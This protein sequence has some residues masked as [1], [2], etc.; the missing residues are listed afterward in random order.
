MFYYGDLISAIEKLGKK[1]AI[2]GSIGKSVLG[3]D[4]PYVLTE[5][6]RGSEKEKTVIITGGIHAR[7]HITVPLVLRLAEAS[8]N[9]GYKTTNIFI[10]CVNPDGLRLAT[11]G[12]SFLEEKREWKKFIPFLR[13]CG[14]DFRLWKANILGVDLNVNFDAEWGLG[15]NNVFY[16][17]AENFV[18]KKPLDQTESQALAEFTLTVRPDITVSYHSKGEVIF[19]NFNQKGRIL[20]RD[21]LYAR[22]IARITGYSFAE[23]GG[24]TGGY[25][26]WCVSRLG[27]PSVT[28][29]VG[30]DS[31]SHPV[32]LENL[33]EIYDKNKR[34]LV[35]NERFLYP[36]SAEK[37]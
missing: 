16:P 6:K 31:L 27:I 23:K 12:I 29:E 5:G 26:D 2:T 9:G 32:G 8:L 34:I 36:H 13:S 11:E 3:L 33:R 20:R 25:K 1:G 18:G 10:P 14:K 37:S 21:Y 4:I 24:S 19:W 7:E 15:K 30:A 28:V 17:G 35:E 22:R